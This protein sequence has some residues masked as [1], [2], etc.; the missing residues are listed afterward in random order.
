MPFKP[1][2]WMEKL[3]PDIIN[4][5]RTVMTAIRRRVTRF[6]SNSPY[7]VAFQSLMG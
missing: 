6:A 3:L 1:L 4:E 7:L 5:R 2:S